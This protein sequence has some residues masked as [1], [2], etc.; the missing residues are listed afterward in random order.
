MT[1]RSGFDKVLNHPAAS[2][3]AL[4]WLLVAV[5]C[6]AIFLQSAFP[7]PGG[8]P[9]IPGMDKLVHLLIYLVLGLLVSHAYGLS[10]SKL[11][12]PSLF[13]VALLSVALYGASDEVHQSFVAARSA[14][15]FDWLADIVGG[16]LGAGLYLRFRRP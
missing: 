13:L 11:S 6:L 9:T 7:T 10:L 4:A 5:Y 12:A 16:G 1:A 15:I 3:P 14:D 2:S 8:L